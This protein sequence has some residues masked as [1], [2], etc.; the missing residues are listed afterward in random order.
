[1]SRDST[2]RLIDIT[3]AFRKASAINDASED[4]SSA[5]SAISA[6]DLGTSGSMRYSLD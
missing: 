6:E 1:M 5:L 4:A 3:S 2:I